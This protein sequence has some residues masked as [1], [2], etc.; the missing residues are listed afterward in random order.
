MPK[1]YTVR[2]LI[3][4]VEKDGWYAIKSKSGHRQFKHAEKSGRV[5]IPFHGTN[6]VLPIKTV[7]SIL[8]QA[9]IKP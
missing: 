2:E 5:T 7:Q 6:E 3:A 8:N 4:I 9:Q 1:R